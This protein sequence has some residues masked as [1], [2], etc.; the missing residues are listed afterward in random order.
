MRTIHLEK[1]TKKALRESR[2]FLLAVENGKKKLDLYYKEDVDEIVRLLTDAGADDEFLSKKYWTSIEDRCSM[3][4]RS[5]LVLAKRTK[6][7]SYRPKYNLKKSLK[8]EGH[9]PEGQ[10]CK[11]RPSLISGAAI[12]KCC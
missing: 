2:G 8:C 1:T 7:K 5:T 4:V 10:E 3:K 6:E 12:C 11:E 9:C